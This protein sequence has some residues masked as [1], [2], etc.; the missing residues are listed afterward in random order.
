MKDL[1]NHLAQLSLLQVLV[2]GAAREGCSLVRF[3]ARIGAQVTLNDIKPAEALM[4]ALASLRNVPCQLA[5]GQIL[6]EL[7]GVDVLFISPGVP[8]T[9]PVVQEARRRG[10]PISSEPRLLAQL[11]PAPIVGVTGSSGKTTTTT[12]I[13]EMQRAAGRNVWVGGNIGRP[14]LERVLDEAA[15]DI[16]V[17]ELSSFQLE[18]FNPDYQGAETEMRRS[19]VSHAVYTGGW[20][21]HVATILNITPNHLD[22]HPT[23]ADYVW[24]K[25]QIL[26]FQQ[27]G[28]WAVL[29]RD[30]PL[31]WELSQ[32]DKGVVQGEI[33]AFSLQEQVPIGAFLRG[34]T[35]TLRDGIRE[36]PICAMSE[37]KLRG[38]HNVANVLAAACCAWASGLEIDPI[39]EVATTFTG[40]PHRLEPVCR[41]RDVLYVNDSIATSP[42]RAIAA[43]HSFREPLIL[44]AGGRDKHLP[45]DDWA[46]LVLKRVRSVVAFGEAVPIIVRALEQAQARAGASVEQGPT[47]HTVASLEDAVALAAS[48]AQPGDVVLLSPGGTSFD[49]FRDFEDRGRRFREL[50]VALA[51]EDTQTKSVSS[52]SL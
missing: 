13:G 29:N 24:A 39:R 46:D 50:V 17:V 25:A 1:N 19:P 30:D 48:L 35:L 6:P 18:L 4:E 16:A 21:P 26:R 38:W 3:F 33:L 14:L 43:L 23:M 34:E 45:W 37:I 42:E 28:D 40:V 47:L 10:L 32:A 15:P 9:A 12:L 51:A 11:C 8:P 41:W 49:A 7:D 2:V 20:S 44:L 5:L 36:R 31:S 52:T 27:A 22:R